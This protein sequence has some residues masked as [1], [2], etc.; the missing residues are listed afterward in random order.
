MYQTTFSD[1]S[2]DKHGVGL[3]TGIPSFEAARRAM[4]YHR[5]NDYHAEAK[6]LEYI[7]VGI[8]MTQSP[9]QRFKTHGAAGA[10]EESRQRDSTIPTSATTTRIPRHRFLKDQQ[11]KS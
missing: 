7:V 4:K 5:K 3:E 6:A 8:S 1:E 2:V 10:R 9:R 11:K